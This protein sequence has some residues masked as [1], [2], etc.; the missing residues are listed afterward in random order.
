MGN[1]VLLPLGCVQAAGESDSNPVQNTIPHFFIK[2]PNRI[3][4]C[5]DWVTL[6]THLAGFSNDF[7]AEASPSVVCSVRSY[8]YDTGACCD[9]CPGVLPE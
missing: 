4:V 8:H 7:G 1:L 9:T 5:S 6:L 2:R 3:W